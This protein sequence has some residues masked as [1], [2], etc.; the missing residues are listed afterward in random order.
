MST[1]AQCGSGI[2]LDLVIVGLVYAA[3]MHFSGVPM[4]SIF[5]GSGR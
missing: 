1:L 4:S 2:V 5:V 3:V